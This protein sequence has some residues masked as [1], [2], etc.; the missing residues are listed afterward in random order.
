MA[1]AGCNLFREGASVPFSDNAEDTSSD[2]C[3]GAACPDQVDMATCEPTSEIELC[4]RLSG[5]CD[6]LETVDD[7][8][9]QRIIDCGAC[10]AR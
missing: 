1:L 4:A 3:V 8:G 7:C 9:S 2:V 5:S 6:L 10:T